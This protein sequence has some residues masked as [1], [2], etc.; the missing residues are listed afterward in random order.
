MSFGE[1]VAAVLIGL[2]VLIPVAF[3]AARESGLAHGPVFNVMRDLFALAMFWGAFLFPPFVAAVAGRRAVLW[4]VLATLVPVVVFTAL[5]WNP[6]QYP[7]GRWDYFWK[8]E[9]GMLAFLIG[10]AFFTSLL[11]HVAQKQQRKAEQPGPPSQL[12]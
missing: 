6:E 12:K 10:W 3:G 8:R 9:A 2:A 1:R 4:G 11:V 5:S 7:G